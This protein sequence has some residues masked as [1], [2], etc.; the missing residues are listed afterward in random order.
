LSNLGLT[1]L[2]AFS[3]DDYVRIAG[4]LARDPPR[5]AALRASL[6]SRM[7]ASVL[8]D[9]PRF[10]HQVET[11]YRAMWRRWCAAR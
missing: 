1:E 5:L 11:A 10:A 2:A 9:A 3:E 8:M 7:E 4:Q 6:R